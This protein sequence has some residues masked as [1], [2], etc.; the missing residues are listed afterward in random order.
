MGDPIFDPKDVMNSG[1][2]LVFNL[3]FSDFYD[4]FYVWQKSESS[5]HVSEPDLGLWDFGST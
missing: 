5:G 1:E 2:C 4:V 3:I